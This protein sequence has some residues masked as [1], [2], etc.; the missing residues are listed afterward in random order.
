MALERR[1]QDELIE[2]HLSLVGYHVSEMIR[3]VPT[4]VQRD[5]LAAAGSLALVQAARG[6]NAELGVP[7]ARYASTRIR[8]AILDELRGMDWASRGTRQ[9]ARRLAELTER[10]TGNLGRAPR[11][12]ELAQ[13]MG[14]GVDELRSIRDDAQR[15]VVSLDADTTDATGS[16]SDR[17][18]S[19]EERVVVDER[20]RYLTA[21]VGELP[22]NLRVV[23]QGIF[24]EERPVVEIAAELGVTQSR[25]SQLRTQALGMLRDAMNTALDPELAPVASEQPGVAE[26]R[27]Q[28]Y[29]A[30][31]A[32][33]ASATALQ[34]VVEVTAA[35]VVSE[36]V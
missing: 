13:A 9:R 27:R 24:F 22:E 21:G 36:A 29:Y 18:P 32:Q 34:T 28:A 23:V 2:Q 3:R 20:L 16:I 15:R 1:E 25:V 19:P 5:E 10:L 14:V 12:D 8:G 17:A 31:V 26:K 6:F 4:H 30:A 33:R 35:A 7:F 11:P